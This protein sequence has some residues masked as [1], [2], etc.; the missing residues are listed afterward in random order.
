MPNSGTAFSK[1][2]HPAKMV[3]DPGISKPGFCSCPKAA[4][5]LRIRRAGAASFRAAAVVIV[6]LLGKVIRVRG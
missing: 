3:V 6:S 5:A 2:S 4:D 1:V